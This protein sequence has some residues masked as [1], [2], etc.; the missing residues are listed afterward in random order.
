M[1]AFSVIQPILIGVNI[2]YAVYKQVKWVSI[3]GWER[4]I[5]QTVLWFELVA[6]LRKSLPYMDSSQ[7][8]A[9]GK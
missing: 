2:A 7:C 5:P 6:N 3:K 8:T 1:Y 9:E 4:S